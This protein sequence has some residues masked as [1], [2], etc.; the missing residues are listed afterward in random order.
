MIV[1]ML[2]TG[3]KPIY[4]KVLTRFFVLSCL[5]VLLEVVCARVLGQVISQQPVTTLNPGQTSTHIIKGGDKPLFELDLTAN[6]FSTITVEQRGIILRATLL[7][8]AGTSVIAMSNPSGGHGPIHISLI[9]AV[10]GKFRVEV[11]STEDWANPGSFEISLSSPRV[12]ATDDNVRI[13]AEA[14]FAKAYDLVE[15]AQYENGIKEYEQALSL[16]KSINDKHWESLTQFSIGSSFRRWGKLKEAGDRFSEALNVQNPQFDTND[17]RLKASILNDLGSTHRQLGDPDKALTTLNEAFNLYKAHNDRRGQASSLSNM[18]ITY[19]VALGELYAPLQP[20]EQALALRDAENDLRGALRVRLNLGTA[21]DVIGDRYKALEYFTQALKQLQDINQVTPLTDPSDLATALNNVGIAYDKLGD[22]G[23][24]MDHYQRALETYK[25]HDPKRAVALDNIGELYA[26]LGDYDRAR[27]YYDLALAFWNSL[28]KP[29]V[30]QKANLLIH[31]GEYYLAQNDLTKSLNFFQEAHDLT[32]NPIQKA[33]AQTYI[34]TVLI[35]QGNPQLAFHRFQRAL[36]IQV[37]KKNRRGEAITRQKQGETYALLGQQLEAVAALD[38]ALNLWRLVQDPR[39][40]AATLH[41][42][43]KVKSDQNKLREALEHSKQAISLVESLR[44]KVSSHQLRTSYFAHQ[45]NYYSLNIDLNMRLYEETR[46]R[47]FL[48]AALHASE[49][50][51]ARSLM[52]S[53][54]E[55]FSKVTEGINPELLQREHQVQRRLQSKQE[56]QTKLLS[57]KFSEKDAT[58]INRDLVQLIQEHNDLKDRIRRSSPR[59]SQLTEPQPIGLEEIQQLLDNDTLLVEFATGEKRSYAWIVGKGSL[60]SV[61]LPARQEIAAT[62]QRVRKAL[63]DRNQQSRGETAI[64]RRA[65]IQRLKEE[66]DVASSLLSQMVLDP[67]R[68]H[69]GKKRLLIVA[70]GDLQM[71]PFAALPAPKD[72]ATE[73]PKNTSETAKRRLIHD[74]EIITVDSASVL[75]LQRRSLANRKPAPQ[76]VAVLAEAVFQLNEPDKEQAR[77]HGKTPKPAPAETANPNG[78]VKNPD[79]TRALRSVGLDSISLLPFSRDEARA[80][81]KVSPRGST[82]IALRFEASRATVMSPALARYRYVHF[83]THGIVDLENPDFS[84]IILSLVDEQGRP[85]DGYIRLH[86]IYNLNLPA[87]LV[88][89]S[90]CETGIGKQ[91]RGEGL[92][93]LTRGFMYAGAKKVVASLWQVQDAATARLMAEFYKEM[94]SNNLPPAAA[95]RAAQITMSERKQESSDPYYWAGFVLQGDWQ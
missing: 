2:T 16:W 24:A 15:S 72:Q 34:G 32:T 81:E 49:R 43:A 21:Y 22:L 75:A 20:L 19:G 44:T 7:D 65:R 11:R 48:A 74:H 69:L 63:V 35:L 83:A 41:S 46:D 33:D 82:K 38:R 10:S 40:E 6:Q 42:I 95:L 54:S 36:D 89:L 57:T 12:P 85:Q 30:N 84:G 88:V 64:Q 61:T 25:P 3:S 9:P 60:E 92:I 77:G 53:L 66:F 45:E 62:A 27:H 76:A 26:A 68:S 13:Q 59:Y 58:A 37:D 93:A 90:A 39:G 67:I 29:E 78:A 52:D 56:A 70:D 80:I 5:F 4:G 17:W 23:R 47:Q 73:T 28:E 91:V 87:E 50:S 1:T 79:L 18:A 51:R 94:F 31:I 71:V 14:A 55:T 86:E 8:P